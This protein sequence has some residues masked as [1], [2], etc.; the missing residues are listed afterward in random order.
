MQLPKS[1]CAAACA[2]GQLNKL[3][4]LQR[5]VE[6]RSASG[7]STNTWPESEWI[8]GVHASIEPL[9]G[10]D[11]WQAQMIAPLATVKITIRYRAGLDG[12]WRVT[13]QGRT[14][15]I[16]GHPIDPYEEHV[17]LVLNC[18]EGKRP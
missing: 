4:T 5:P 11:L 2:A 8:S 1:A 9:Q 15:N 6:V 17:F 12:D 18:I 13:Y 3:V 14:F 16:V 10:R 7:Q